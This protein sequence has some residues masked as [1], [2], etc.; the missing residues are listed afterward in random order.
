MVRY[1]GAVGLIPKNL[2]L[3]EVN[4]LSVIER[5]VIKKARELNV[6]FIRLQFTDI[7]GHFKN[8]AITISQL[9]RAFEE[10]ILFDG[11]SIQGFTRIHESDMYLRPDPNTLTIFPWRPKEG[12]AVARLICDIYTPKGEPF[13]GCP[14]N[15]LRRVIAEAQEMGYEMYA[16][17]EPEF[18]LFETDE[19]G[20]P[21]K[22]TNDT[23]SYFDL[24][25]LDRGEDARRDIAITLEEM[26]FEIE[27]SHHEVAPGQHEIDLRFS[28]C[29]SA[30]D[31]LA[32]FRFVVKAIAKRHGLHASF[33]PK[34]FF[35]ENGSG[36]HIHQSLFQKGINVFADPN[37]EMGLSDLARSY[38]AGLMKHAPALC[39]IGNPTVN[40]YK[41]L[42][43]GYEAPVDITWSDKDRST[44][45]R[46]PAA[47]GQSTR[48]ELRSP[49][50]AANPYLIIAASLKAGL[51]G[52]RE[53][54]VPP[55][56]TAASTYELN[57]EE[58]R[59][60]GVRSLPRN[61]REAL[62]HLANDTV[63]REM[64]GEHI[65]DHYMKAK[66]VEWEVFSTQVHQWETEQYL[67]TL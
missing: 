45:I 48:V 18:F 62:D 46:I 9:E 30:A 1:N 50:P 13:A 35:G 11:S 42:V 27:S 32:T 40:S 55:P 67:P 21:T 10:G 3:G 31:N 26:G 38:V 19:R 58:R 64:L 63:L 2:T 17:P 28:D 16:G 43:P 25:P 53:Q 23:G 7:L 24:S 8:L 52:I 49:D 36:L 5:D 56:P 60:L 66:L 47:G 29:L 15:C 59:V 6:R 39:A 57:A 44:F 51:D 34:P 22:V 37:G 61:L 41:R 12:G 14:R 4:M 33:M 65:Y 20:R 54:L